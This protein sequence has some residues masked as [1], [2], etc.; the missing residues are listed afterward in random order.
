MIGRDLITSIATVM[1]ALALALVLWAAIFVVF[2]FATLAAWPIVSGKAL[3]LA[4]AA[5]ISF[6]V[7]PAGKNATVE[8]ARGIGHL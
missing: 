7:M 1:A 6:W 8:R 2:A 5:T 3:S 4:E